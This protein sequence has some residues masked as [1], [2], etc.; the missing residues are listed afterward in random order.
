MSCAIWKLRIWSAAPEGR[1]CKISTFAAASS[2]KASG[3]VDLL[4]EALARLV[5]CTFCI[6]N[7]GL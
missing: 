6:F 2:W 7:L 4:A 1:D 3:A 5:A